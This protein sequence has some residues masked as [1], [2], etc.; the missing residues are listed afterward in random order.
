LKV[1]WPLVLK[2]SVICLQN[3][4]NEHIP[5][6]SWDLLILAQNTY[7]MTGLLDDV[8]SVLQDLDVNKGS[9]PDG[10]PPII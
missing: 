9:G 1:V 4:Y 8:K 6:M 5:M 2:K 7:K 10:I 3:L